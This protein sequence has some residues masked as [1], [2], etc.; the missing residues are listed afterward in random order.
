MVIERNRF[1][2]KRAAIRLVQR[3]TKSFVA[4]KGMRKELIAERDFKNVEALKFYIRKAS[5]VQRDRLDQA[6]TK[7]QRS[8]HVKIK[9]RNK[10]KQLREELK[11]LPMVV[12]SNYVKMYMLKNQT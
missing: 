2:K 8:I 3:Y 10:G 9:N 7:I 5:D 6:A 4:W 1:L 11:K 12:R